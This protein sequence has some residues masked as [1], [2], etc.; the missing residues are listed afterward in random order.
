ML[1]T[2]VAI[3]AAGANRNRASSVGRWACSCPARPIRSNR[4]FTIGRQPS[5]WLRNVNGAAGVNPVLLDES[6]YIGQHNY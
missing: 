2:T 4:K 6:P 5:R 3:T 1:R